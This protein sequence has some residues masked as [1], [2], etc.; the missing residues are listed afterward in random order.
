MKK[1]ILP[2]LFLV[3]MNTYAIAA[4]VQYDESVSGDINWYADP[5]PFN[6]ELGINTLSGSN[7]TQPSSGDRDGFLFN[8]AEG[9]VL[10]SITL[11]YS[12]VNSDMTDSF[13]GKT[14]SIRLDDPFGEVVADDGWRFLYHSTNPSSVSPSP[15]S[16]FTGALPIGAGLYYF[17]EGELYGSQADPGGSFDYTITMEITQA[18]S[19][20]IPTTIS[21]LGI[22]I[23]GLAGVSRRKN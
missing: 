8:I 1:N 14:Y 9:Q 13:W 23:L 12:N 18:A 3:L 20:P 16:L 11:S 5:T 15:I 21:L 22:G 10:S 6:L 17:R 4:P 7:S 19:V 2:L